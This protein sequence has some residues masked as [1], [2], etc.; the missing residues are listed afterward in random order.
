MADAVSGGAL[1]LIKLFPDWSY[2][3]SAPLSSSQGITAVFLVLLALVF[4]WSIGVFLYHLWRS[5]RRISFLVEKLK[6]IK[7]DELIQ[8][9]EQVKIDMDGDKDCKALWGEFDESLVASTDSGS[10]HLY[11][12]IDAAH[13][14]DTHTLARGM[15]ES[16]LIAA[17]PGILTAI[18]VL[19]TFAGLTLG[20]GGLGDIGGGNTKVLEQ[21]ISGMIQSASI[22]FTTS[23]WGVLFSVIF[24]VI[25]KVCES[26]IRKKISFLQD[27]IDHLFP[28]LTPE[29]MLMDISSY[30][31]SSD[32]T[33]LGLAEKIGDRMQ[34]AVIQMKDEISMG[35]ANALHEV[36]APAIGKLVASAEDMTKRQTHSSE[37]ALEQVIKKF[38]ADFGQAGSEQGQM[39]R[40]SV[41]SLQELLKK[42]ESDQERSIKRS[43]SL[44]EK[45]QQVLV[46][47][48]EQISKQFNQFNLV[49]EK[50]TQA[51]ESVVRQQEDVTKNVQKVSDDLLTF[52]GMIEEVSGQLSE[53]AKEIKQGN[54][55]LAKTSQVMAG[56]VSDAA[57][58]NERVSQ[59]NEETSQKLRG[60]LDKIESSRASAEEISAQLRSSAEAGAATFNALKEHQEGYRD[61]LSEHVKELGEQ[62]A[63]VL[64]QYAIEVENQTHDR[65]SA[66]DQETIKYT[67]AM[68]G[69]VN[70]MQ[71]AVAEMQEMFDE[72]RDKK[73]Q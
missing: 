5:H 43:D 61:A 30:S 55:E 65:M 17:M 11:N 49:G 15:T 50:N 16:R 33:M 63:T 3:A 66:W 52:A 1:N 71:E 14:F 40:E 46:D 19:G 68:Q 20:L 29:K 25:E 9:R 23:F 18:G 53:A 26:Y 31:K 64:Q 27:Y 13:F 62:L 12:T 59:S 45:R 70:A 6:D 32:E 2:L 38:M 42:M 28:R 7:S 10:R 35:M 48:I 36:L 22:A 73:N 47:A 39:M 8:K 34:E 60:L 57:K 72:I 24:N 69:V 4:L 58:S 56:A 21:G 51:A 54:Q 67:G 37:G 44:E 41:Q